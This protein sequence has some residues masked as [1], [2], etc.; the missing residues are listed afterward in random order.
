MT[1]EQIKS[2]KPADFKRLCGVDPETFENTIKVVA[3]EKLFQTKTGRLP[4][5]PECIQAGK[6]ECIPHQVN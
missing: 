5:Q 2:L 3:A 1:K 6:R 4:T